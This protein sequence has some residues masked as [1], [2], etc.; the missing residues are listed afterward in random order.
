[1]LLTTTLFTLA[2]TVSVCIIYFSG[3]SELDPGFELSQSIGPIY[4]DYTPAVDYREFLLKTRL[5]TKFW[6]IA[7]RWV[8]S[9]PLTAYYDNAFIP[10]RIAG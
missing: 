3:L 1:M 7:D 4:L 2:T 10:P 5:N 8:L 9:A 6:Y